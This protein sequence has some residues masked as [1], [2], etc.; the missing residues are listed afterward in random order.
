MIKGPVKNGK[1][2]GPDRAG[3]RLAKK[4]IKNL[5]KANGFSVNKLS[6][7]TGI[8]RKKLEDIETFREWGCFIYVDDIARIAK[9][10]GV[11]PGYFFDRNMLD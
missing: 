4:L 11:G 7:A 9:A 10:L 6:K 8:T 1:F 3:T 5:R 2:S